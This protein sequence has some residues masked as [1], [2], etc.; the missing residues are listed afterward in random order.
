M[1]YQSKVSDKIL[2]WPFPIKYGTITQKETDILI[3]GCGA[4]GSCAAISA[5]RRGLKVAVADKAPIKRSGNTGAGMDHWNMITDGPDSPV[6]AEKQIEKELMPKTSAFFGGG[7]KRGHENYIA[8]KGTWDALMEL[9]KLGLP[10]QDDTGDF[11]GTYTKDKATGLLKAYDYEHM[12]SVK[13]RGGHYIKPVLFNALRNL[14]VDFYERVMMTRLL[15]EDGKQGAPIVG[16]MGFSLETGEIFVFHAKSVVIATAGVSSIWT[17]STEITGKSTG[18][19]P[20]EVGEGVVMALEAGAYVCGFEACG[21]V[22]G[23]NPLGWP[24]FGGGNASNTWYPCTIVDDD[25]K[26]ISWYDD[27]GE[28]VTDFHRLNTRSKKKPPTDGF[29]AP[30]HLDPQLSD[31]IRNGEYKM[32]LWADLSDLPEEERRS[33]WGVMIGNEGKTRY[34]IFDY[35]TRHGFNPNLDL[36]WAPIVQPESLRMGPNW[37]CEPNMMKAWRSEQFARGDVVTDWNLMSNVR[38]LFCAGATCGLEGCSYACSS[39]F[40]AG[41]RAAEYTEKLNSGKISIQQVENERERILHPVKI[42]GDP[43]ARISWKEMW[44]GTTRVMQSCCGEWKNENVLKFGLFWLNSIRDNEMQEMYARNPH[45]LG[46]VLECTTRM[47]ASEM[48][49]RAALAKIEDGVTEGTSRQGTQPADQKR[50]AWDAGANNSR[51]SQHTWGNS[52]PWNG[53]SAESNQKTQDPHAFMFNYFE[54]GEFKTIFREDRYWLKPPYAESYLENYQHARSK[55]G[56]ML[57]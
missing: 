3:I 15:T 2:E 54:N 40:Y 31:R 5:A 41:N 57:K 24:Y 16:A 30:A 9:E 45:E 48:F 20:N 28:I 46:R 32:P 38:G 21:K 39:G 51:S 10:I 49:L 56:R 52:G 44:G 35:Y 1:D 50:T 42:L 29:Y 26:K 34:S 12:V 6:T 14:G 17:Y 43:E 22:G 11:D 7:K 47:R 19:D 37:R 27:D 13:L 36:L 8:M 4:A 25:G 23:I 18:W 55:E 33:I 53:T